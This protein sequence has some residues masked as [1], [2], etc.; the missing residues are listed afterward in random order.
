M[1]GGAAAHGH[2]GQHS[3]TRKHEKTKKHHPVKQHR[4]THHEKHH[5][6]AKGT[7][8]KH[9][10]ARGYALAPWLLPVC[11]LEAVAMSL[12]LAGQPVH[13]DEVAWLWE[14]CGGR[15]LSIGEALQA[16]ARSGLAGCRPVLWPVRGEV[17]LDPGHADALPVG[18]GP[19]IGP[20]IA[21]LHHL[22][23]LE[24]PQG[25]V[26]P[27]EI[28]GLAHT[29]SFHGPILGPGRESPRSAAAVLCPR[30]QAGLPPGLT[31]PMGLMPP[32]WTDDAVQASQQFIILG[33][34]RP[35]P[36]AVLATP[37]G[38]W[39]WGQLY[40]PWPCTVEEIVAVSWS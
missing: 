20:G 38:W 3:G 1:S 13:D 31:R 17:P 22:G 30:A 12:R 18:I 11:S 9:A 15:E 32:L 7:H 4:A 35:G 24:A 29:A 14:L 36:H 23:Y 25:E 21:P 8:V 28:S 16:A 40:D 33:V 6:H 37:R 5:V 2:T 27:G 19:G 39:S 26:R 10:K 34:D